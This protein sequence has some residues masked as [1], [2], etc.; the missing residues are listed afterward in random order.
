MP[1]FTNTFVGG[2]DRDTVPTN[3]DN[4]KYYNAKNFSIVVA[5]D[6][7]SA[8]LT[9]TKGI[10]SKFIDLNPEGNRKI[11]GICS[12]S[13]SLIIFVKGGGVD[14]KKGRIHEILFTEL[15]AGIVDLYPD[16]HLIASNDLFDFGDRVEAITREE[17]PSIRK[18]YWVDG[19][20]PIRFC[21]LALDLSGY[22]LTQF[23]INQEV[24]FVAPLYSKLISGKLKSGVYQYAYCLYNQNAGQTC[25]S[26]FSQFI[27]ISETGL[28]SSSTLFKGSAIGID[29][30]SG[31][32][33]NIN[34]SNTNFQYIR[35]ISIFYTTPEAVP[36]ITII[37]EG[38][39]T[40]S[41]TVS[42]TGAQLL[43]T[44]VL[45]EVISPSMVLIPKTLASKYN[46]LLLGNILEKDFDVD[47]DAR[48]YRFNSSG[49]SQ[50]YKNNVDYELVTYPNFPTTESEYNLSIKNRLDLDISPTTGNALY[51]YKGNGY[52]YGGE[53]PNVSYTFVKDTLKFREDP[54]GLGI[55]STNNCVGYCDPAQNNN[56]GYQ[57]DEIYR[58]G[59]V[60]FNSKGQS[61]F[62]KWIGDI[63]MPHYL[64]D[65]AIT[66][67]NY[68]R[69]LSV[70]FTFNFIKLLEEYPDIV[71]Y[72]VVRAER[73]YND[74]TVVDC[75][76]IGHLQKDSSFLFWGG[77]GTKDATK[78]SYPALHSSIET[79]HAPKGIVEYIC[80]ETNY[81]KNN[82]GSYDRLDIHDSSISHN[83]KKTVP[84]IYPIYGNSYTVD[85]VVLS[86]LL[87]SA[88]FGSI[89]KINSTVLF[90]AQRSTSALQSLPS[91]FGGYSLKTRSHINAG[92]SRGYK[93]TTLVMKLDSDV[94]HTTIN[95]LTDDNPAY[96]LRRSVTYPYGGYSLSAIAS[97]KYYPCSAIQSISTNT[98]KV[99]G[100]DTYITKFEYMR[101]LWADNST[102]D[103]SDDR[104][105]QVVQCMVESKLNLDYTCNPRWSTYDNNIVETQN[106]VRAG[107]TYLAL[108]EK[109]GTWEFYMN[110]D[111]ATKYFIQ[112]DDLYTY[113][114]VYSL[115]TGAK[116]FISKPI[117][118]TKSTSYPTRI[119]VSE[120]KI[121]GELTDSWLSFLTNNFI[122]LDN[123]FGNLTRLYN[124]NNRLFYFQKNGF[125][126]I[127]IEDREVINT[128]TGS[129]VSIGTGGVLERYDYIN[130]NSGTTLPNSIIGTNNN[131]YFID[132]TA[133]KLCN[134]V[135]SDGFRYLSDEEGLYSYLNNA[136]LTDV[137]SIYNPKTKEVIFSFNNQSNPESLIYNEYTKTFVS[138]SDL[139]FKY[140]EFDNGNMYVFNNVLAHTHL[141]QISGIYYYC[142]SG[143]TLNTGSYGKYSLEYPTPDTPTAS[144]LELIINP[145]RNIVGRLD[146]V[147]LSTE[148]YNGI[149]NQPITTF[150]TI[151]LQNNYQ[152]TGIITL[153]PAINITRRFRTWRFN[154][155]RNSTDE[156]RLVDNYAKLS[157]NFTN[158]GT[159]KIIVS[160]IITTFSPLNIK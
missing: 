54:S 8:T 15:E 137:N 89:V 152:D 33:I 69:V 42:H 151:Q 115:S 149:T 17:T 29:T 76:Y 10:S 52:T 143:A 111:A 101:T 156:G 77:Y 74:A 153:V 18:I 75:G 1:K 73:T 127:P 78:D 11:V 135:D 98:I 6:L 58:F 21:N 81:N 157:L 65:F 86:S 84:N 24:K 28:T 131:L 72:Q 118:F 114:S 129:P 19:Q 50:M 37:Y 133:K 116:S 93:G 62:V 106:I 128:S 113:N 25:Y 121:N 46:Y 150:S 159:N 55:W 36:E 144:T 26:P 47:F 160:D 82:D 4:K 53:G 66:A 68:I 83:V 20:N 120:K 107:Y 158:N 9:N 40:L 67:G 94:S 92:G 16:T 97:S 138:F 105:S 141:S 95:K 43:G 104:Y 146:T 51:K 87:P 148:V 140:G 145:A 44:A 100:G 71:S 3:Y 142:I 2:L 13:I 134:L 56:V 64:D 110:G 80:P 109:S 155:I 154:T 90:K 30:T 5:E 32:E 112:T 39:K 91:S 88:E 60:F 124:H 41:L 125:G 130:T 108:W 27:Q 122:D 31:I 22:N 119:R 99:K 117:N 96:V 79:S 34:D 102:E 139:V 85:N 147:E 14:D 123:Q 7:S 35:V 23:E 49:V 70:M 103:W 57:R 38:A 48:T 12:T 61:S 126:V 63:R 45:E 136:V 59:I 132:D